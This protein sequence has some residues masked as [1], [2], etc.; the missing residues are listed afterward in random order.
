MANLE[1]YQEAV[2]SLLLDISSQSVSDAGIESQT[3]FDT[4][5]N[6]Y[7]VVHVGWHNHH[8][9]YGCVLHVDIKDG[10]I[11]VQHN[12]T[13]RAI[14]DDLMERGVPAQDIVLGFHSPSKRKFTEFAVG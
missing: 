7:Q 2:Q 3:L 12:G 11:W 14:A 9:V 10:K 6:H 13:E 8:R 1:T 4:V 5:R